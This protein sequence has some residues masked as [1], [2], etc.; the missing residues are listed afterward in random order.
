MPHHWATKSVT[1]AEENPHLLLLV[2][3]QLSNHETQIKQLV[4]FCD[5]DKN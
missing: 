3:L 2:I 1:K 4:I 5:A